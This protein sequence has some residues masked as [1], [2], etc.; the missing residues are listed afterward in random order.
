MK[1][2]H[3][4][5]MRGPP[6]ARNKMFRFRAVNFSAGKKPSCSSSRRR[7]CERVMGFSTVIGVHP[8]YRSQLGH[9]GGCSSL[10]EPMSARSQTVGAPLQWRSPSIAA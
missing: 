5:I 7:L 4:R 2:G 10:S 8:S 9:P 1:R 6:N 3:W